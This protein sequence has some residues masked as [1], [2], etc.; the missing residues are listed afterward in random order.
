MLP[1]L[2]RPEDQETVYGSDK[3]FKSK[4][5]QEIFVRKWLRVDAG[6]VE[7]SEVRIETLR[8]TL[9]LRSGL[10]R[11]NLQSRLRVKIN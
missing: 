6:L 10:R 4:E 5:E 7:A 2:E 9:S 11:V 8:Y 1:W 3:A